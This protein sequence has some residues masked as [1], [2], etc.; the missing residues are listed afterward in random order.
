[1]AEHGVRAGRSRTRWMSLHLRS[2]VVRRNRG[3]LLAP[4]ARMA[5]DR[6]RDLSLDFMHLIRFLETFGKMACGDR[7][8]RTPARAVRGNQNQRHAGLVLHRTVPASALRIRKGSVSA[9]AL[10]L[11]CAGAS[12]A[13]TFSADGGN[14]D[15]LLR[16][17]SDRTGFRFGNRL[18]SGAC[19]SAGTDFGSAVSACAVLRSC[20][21]GGAALHLPAR[22]R[23]AQIRRILEPR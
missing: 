12:G 3:L 18:L 10:A 2:G 15:S 16:K 9:D 21:S 7:A 1:M 23:N 14:R 13:E 11:C 5:G 6:T 20:A 19:R 17:R 4:A 8:C 22:I